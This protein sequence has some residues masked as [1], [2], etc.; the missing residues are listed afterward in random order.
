MEVF[1]IN[2]VRKVYTIS[3]GEAKPI[4]I[5]EY[6]DVNMTFD[7]VRKKYPKEEIIKKYGEYDSSMF[8]TIWDSVDGTNRM[9]GAMYWINHSKSWYW[10]NHDGNCLYVNLPNGSPWNIDSRASNC[11][12]PKERTHR[13]W[14]YHGEPPNITVDKNGHTCKAGAGSIQMSDYHGFL[15]S[16]KFT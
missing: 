11:T 4:I 10:D 8:S 16:G 1:L 14:C 9:A 13:C 2:P 7:E 5:A 15:R 12:M 6:D 3:Q